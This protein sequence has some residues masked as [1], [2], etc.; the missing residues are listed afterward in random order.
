MQNWEFKI[1]GLD[2]AVC[3]SSV[4]KE[5]KSQSWVEECSLQFT[6]SKLTISANIDEDVQSKVEKIVK[7]KEPDVIITL[8]STTFKEA[9]IK[10]QNGYH[11]WKDW[12]TYVFT[13]GVLLSFVGYFMFESTTFIT[14]GF[15]LSCVGGALMLTKTLERAG[16]KLFKGHSIDE[17]LLVAISVIGAFAIKQPL[18]ALMVVFLYQI[19]KFL[20]MRAINNSRKNL[21]ALLKIKPDTTKVRNGEQIVELAPKDVKI[22][23]TLV[24]Y[25][26]DTIAL[27][28]ILLSDSATLNMQSI[29]GESK[30]VYIKKGDKVLS[31]SINLDGLVEIKST[32]ND[33]ES[34]VS[35]IMTLVE[36]ATERKAKA[37]T[38]VSK[39][40][41]IYT[42]VVIALAFIVG[43]M[44]YFVGHAGVENSIYK[45]MIFLVISCPCAIAISVPLSYFASIGNASKKGAIVKGSN[46]I[47]SVANIKTVIFD[48]TG[49]LTTGEFEVT[50]IE[51][52]S[53]DFDE[54][55]LLDYAVVGE[56]NSNHPI[57]KAI[58]NHYVETVREKNCDCEHDHD[59]SN[60]HCDCG[61][62]HSHSDEHCDCGHD[63]SHSDEHCDCGH[64]HSHSDEHCDCGHDHNHSSNNISTQSSNLKEIAGKG[65][66]FQ[67]E[68]NHVEVSRSESNQNSTIVNIFVNSV[69]VG[70]IY[71]NDKVKSSS[72]NAIE[73]LKKNGIKTVMLTGDNQIVAESVAKE[74][75]VD[76]FKA[77]LLPQDKFDELEKLMQT[78]NKKNELFAYIGDGINDAPVLTRADIGVSMGKAGSNIAIETSDIVLMNDDLETFA[79]LHKLSKFTKLNV[80]EN[81]SFALAI[82]VLFMSLGVAGI[83]G[84]A[85]AVV[86]DVGLSLMTIFNSLRVARFSGKS[87]KE[88]QQERAVEKKL[89]KQKAI[90]DKENE[91]QSENENK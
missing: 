52:L 82:K 34:T 21:D 73:Y 12:F 27:D 7:S 67:F 46:Y 9:K 87:F 11:W 61:H 35:K 56:Q 42:P 68:N 49:T 88:R 84:L 75:G 77:E 59:H 71:L 80:A 78:R 31:G 40:A 32:T 85:W 8:I 13:I 39:A 69:L 48:K 37:E 89:A 44:F 72:K 24:A 65:I 47:D 45:G 51:S 70:K 54:K 5:L 10:K 23:S 1:E 15:A 60:E 58:V 18:E 43:L 14:A 79:Q 17:N 6:T 90:E 25:A 83:T 36:T 66:E 63:H 30:P 3:A 86:A 2:C 20:E 38:F 53:Q 64:D 26:G 57:A 4:E 22:G 41:K 74:L 29:T 19:G 91:N 81:I 50:Q 62:D 33:S 76:N 16:I 28:G 55:K